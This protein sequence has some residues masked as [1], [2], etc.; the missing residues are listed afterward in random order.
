VQWAS[1]PPFP[2]T[3]AITL[4]G[5]PLTPTS[6]PP[7]GLQGFTLADAESGEN[8]FSIRG[9]LD[10]TEGT[11]WGTPVQVCCTVSCQ[12]VPCNPPAGLRLWQA[13]YGAEAAL[14]ALW[15]NGESTYDAVNG[16]VNGTL[17]GMLPGNA[18][19]AIIG[20]FSAG[21][22][23]IAVEGDCGGAGRSSRA[24]AAIDVRAETPHPTPVVGDIACVFNAA[25]GSTTAA[26]TNGA[27]SA[28]I[29]V[30][31]ARGGV[32]ES[33]VFLGSIAG[34]RTS[35][36]VTDTTAADR[37]LLQFFTY[38][39]GGCYGSELMSC[40]AAPP[41]G[42]RFIRGLC[43]GIAS[44]P[45]N[46]FPGITSAVFLFNF[47]FLGGPDPP[48]LEA[49][50]VDGQ[51]PDAMPVNLTDGVYLLNFLF[52]AGPPPAGWI[53]AT[54]DGVVDPT[55]ETAPEAVC[56]ASHDFCPP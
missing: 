20:P 53:D 47:L 11:Y 23:T 19:G 2:T 7:G 27:P 52:L 25:A 24:E 12:D 22:H 43:N 21:R 46:P 40:T 10:N 17:A 30:Y 3:Y 45:E 9:V 32:P 31:L 38:V 6:P 16:Y 13:A 5:V 51:G 34:D 55:C 33:A 50:D 15:V 39:A 36:G 26:W 41:T 37:L 18:G 14:Q 48:C 8:C 54:G 44:D 49:C 29:D 28:F 56:A 42:N 4:G 35:V 1:L